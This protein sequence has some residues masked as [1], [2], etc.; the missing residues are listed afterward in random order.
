MTGEEKRRKLKEEMKAQYK[1]D[2]QLRKE[3]L[4]QAENLKR[5]QKL[6]QSISEIVGGLEDDSD[7]WINQLNQNSAVTEA[8]LDMMLGEASETA[9]ELDKL[10]KEAES[11]KFAAE[12]LVRQ[13]KEE[14]GMLP[15][16]VPAEEAGD[17]PEAKD[18]KEESG[19]GKS[20]KSMGD[21]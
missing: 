15:K 19:G 6:N 16:E 20:G 21:L 18:Q 12:D 10:A 5:S 8:K 7:D 1:R 9:K 4:N 2:L 11:Q 3:F 14:M 13:M 17:T